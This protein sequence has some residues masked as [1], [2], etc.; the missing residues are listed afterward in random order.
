[1]QIGHAGVEIEP[2]LQA[3]EVDSSARWAEATSRPSG[4]DLANKKRGR[5]E[6][7][8]GD[9]MN[10]LGDA[11]GVDEFMSLELL[12]ETMA[13]D[14]YDSVVF[15][16]APTGHTLRLLLLPKMLDGWIGKMITLRGYFSKIGRTIRRLMPK[17]PKGQEVDIDQNLQTA[18]ERVMQARD[19]IMDAER[20]LFALVTIPEAMS[21]FETQRTLDQ[22]SSNSIPVGVVIA[23]QVQPQFDSCDHCQARRAIHLRELE[24]LKG[25]IGQVP[26]RQVETSPLVI[27]GTDALAE[28]GGRM[29]RSS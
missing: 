13:S 7:A 11:P 12:L 20:T 14:A 16:T 6:R 28:L 15:D 19:L 24:R 26:L 9:A 5:L 1:M 27:R 8:L 29:W 23:N 4:P 25:L 3:I 21:V 17:V 18:R 22:L 10:M 2:N